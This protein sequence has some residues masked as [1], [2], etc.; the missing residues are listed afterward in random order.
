M[1]ARRERSAPGFERASLRLAASPVYTVGIRS[2]SHRETQREDSCATSLLSGARPAPSDH[3]R[4]P[5]DGY[6]YPGLTLEMDLEVR[7]SASAA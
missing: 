1:V 4:R 2:A 6:F 7:G 3:G 5:A